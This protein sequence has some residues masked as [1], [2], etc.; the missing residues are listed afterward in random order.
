VHVRIPKVLVHDLEAPWRARGD[1]EIYFRGR[2]SV[3][4][5]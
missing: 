4:W 5:Q 3:F 2:E 1:R